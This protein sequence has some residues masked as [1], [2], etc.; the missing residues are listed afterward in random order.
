MSIV[1]GPE[2][3]VEIN[4]IDWKSGLNAATVQRA[5]AWFLELV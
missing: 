3:V 4:S 1:C 5:A 2:I